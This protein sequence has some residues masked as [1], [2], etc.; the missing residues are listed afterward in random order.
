MDL[1]SYLEDRRELVD[2]AL[3]DVLPKVDNTFS[4]LH[5]AM[6]YSL[7]AGGKRVRP[8]LAMEAAEVVGCDRGAVLPLAV[9]LECIHTYS[10]VHDDLPAMD[11]DDLRRGK[12]TL[13]KAFGEA[14]AILAGDALLTFAFEVMSSPASRR[15]FRP[16]QLLA[17]LHELAFASGSRRLIGGQFLDISNENKDVD[18]ETV[19]CIVANKTTA[20]IR[21]SLTCG[22]RLGGGSQEEIEILGQYGNNLGFAFQIRDDLLDIDG[23]CSMLG[24]AVKKDQQRG[25]ATFPM[26]LGKERAR[27]MM[28]DHI[29]TALDVVRPLGPRTEMLVQLAAYI[30]KRV[31]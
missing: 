18:T 6:R 12:P 28:Q 17:V 26:L 5:R 21:A 8:I 27:E 23:D 13:H 19:E 25:K 11:N 29:E 20:L 22:A 16:E 1:T 3:D 24:K 30:G 15:L 2:R 14:I 10:L 4:L 7:F 9:A 31:N